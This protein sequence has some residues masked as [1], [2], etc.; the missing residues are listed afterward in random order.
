MNEQAT[1]IGTGAAIIGKWINYDINQPA[2]HPKEC[3]KYL[4]CRKDGKIHFE[5]WN[6]TGF[7]YNNNSVKYYG[8]V[9][10]P[11]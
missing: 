6:G 4:V 8:K 11:N 9:L 1:L 7:A 2:S 5:K 10:L 3:G